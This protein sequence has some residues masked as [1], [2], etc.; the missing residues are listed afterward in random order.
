MAASPAA[1]VAII[2]SAGRNEDGPK[3]TAQLFQQ[4]MDCALHIVR[5][6]F[7]LEAHQVTLVSGG[8]AFADHVAVALWL[9]RPAAQGFA[10]LELYLPCAWDGARGCAI[11]TGHWDWR[12]NPGRLANMLHR[13]F[14][15]R[16]GRRSLA[17]IAAAVAQ[18]AVINADHSGFH[19]RNS[20]IALQ[21]T[22]VIA[23]TFSDSGAPKDG[24]T[25]DTWIKC[26]INAAR[27]IH[28]PLPLLAAGEWAGPVKPLSIS[29]CA[30]AV[31]GQSDIVS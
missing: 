17:E 1:R 23:F 6:V 20:A 16:T 22:H 24:G 30:S 3:V 12:T 4:M 14:E 15:Q 13:Q 5:N 27:K 7:G 21:A 25:L 2:G 18:G 9:A 8:A 11:D 19:A 28:V 26:K 10:G 31:N 29:G